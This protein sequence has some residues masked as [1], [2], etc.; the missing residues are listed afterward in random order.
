MKN[1]T[2]QKLAEQAKLRPFYDGQEE[3]FQEFV[4]LIVQECANQLEAN[5]TAVYDPDQHHAYWNCGVKWAVAK[6]QKHIT[7]KMKYIECHDFE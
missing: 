2:I 3:A 1:T 7:A 4:E 6:L 5:R